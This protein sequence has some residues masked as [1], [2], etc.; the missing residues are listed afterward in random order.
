MPPAGA[1]LRLVVVSSIWPYSEH[2]ARAAN[3]VLFE[4]C[5]ALRAVG[6]H[7]HL[8]VVQRS[9]DPPPTAAELHGAEE[10]RLRGV[11]VEPELRLPP[12]YRRSLPLRLLHP[13]IDDFL[14]EAIHAPIAT[15]AIAAI[16]PDATI[17]IWSE[18][19]TALCADVPGIRFAYYGNPDPKVARLR[20]NWQR[21]AGGP[22]WRWLRE[23]VWAAFME[24]VHLRTMRR[25][26]IAANVAA[27]DAAWYRERGH[28][29]APY[30]SNIWTD[31]FDTAWISA[32]RQLAGPRP[33][34]IV[35]SVG[36][37]FGTANQYGLEWLG[38]HLLPAMIRQ[39]GDLEWNLHI[40][41]AG[42]AHPLLRQ[43]L[44]HPRVLWRG[45]VDDIDAEIARSAAFLCVNNATD[46]KV[47]HTR[48]LH[49]W[50]VGAC[51]V[52]HQ[53]ATLSQPELENG[54]NALLGTDA[55]G[56]AMH[57]CNSLTDSGLRHRIGDAGRTTFQDRCTAPVVAREIIGRITQLGSGSKRMTPEAL[58]STTDPMNPSVGEG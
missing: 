44:D 30:V 55:T 57:L 20:S 33:T 22:L 9:A 37:L 52:A 38:R 45:F 28:P 56:M 53:D 6:A 4:L 49:A 26:H 21:R 48:Y 25:F 41:G 19:A 51:V 8:L 13:R 29:A 17:I 12:A 24:R 10:L 15:R 35:A 3:I 46:Y 27:N 11:I 18:W 32:Q 54:V 31:R 43:L 5:A 42:E 14:P 16:A 36:K 58:T 23:R 39:C 34:A 50:S 40:L 1:D 2:S 7:V 47:C